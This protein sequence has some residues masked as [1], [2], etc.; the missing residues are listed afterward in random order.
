MSSVCPNCLNDIKTM[1]KKNR[2]PGSGK[3]QMVIRSVYLLP[4]CCRKASEHPTKCFGTSHKQLER[5]A[6]GTAGDSPEECCS[7]GQATD[8]LEVLKTQLDKSLNNKASSQLCCEQ[9]SWTRHF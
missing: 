5:T 4:K 3:N 2:R 7:L 1:I 9:I 6:A 8:C